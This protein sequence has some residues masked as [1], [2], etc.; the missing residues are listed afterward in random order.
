[1][2]S[3]RMLHSPH[4][5]ASHMGTWMADP[6]FMRA[7]LAAI[8]SGAA[9]PQT[10]AGIRPRS[11]LSMVLDP[12]DPEGATVLYGIAPGGVA[13][14]ELTGAL[15][16]TQS[17]YGGTSTVDARRAMRHAADNPDVAAVMLAIDSPG[18]TTAGTQQLA[19]EVRATDAKKPTFAHIED[20][21]ASAAYWAASQARR[22]TANASALVGSLGTFAVIED[23]SQQAAL[24][25]V[26][27]HVISTG[28]FKG[29]GVN[30]A[31]ISSAYLAEAQRM[32]DSLNA[33]FLTS[34]SSGRRKSP[35]ATAALFDGRVHIAADALG[36]GLI[37]AVTSWD[38]AL[39]DAALSVAAGYAAANQRRLALSRQR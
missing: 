11:D 20:L 8:R 25:G 24:E 32:V 27:V 26:Q 35:E 37:D 15:M 1:M 39:A 6:S 21:G 23:T 5:F 4:C 22:V 10:A 36:L 14:I 38:R 17:K 2:K 3:P 33:L 31:P 28:P 12:Q 16:K 9:V 19:D 34:V 13:V 29:A 30:G 18:G 7:A